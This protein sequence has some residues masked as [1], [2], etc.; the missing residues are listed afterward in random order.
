MKRK[1]FI[2]FIIILFFGSY[3]L[4]FFSYFFEDFSYLFED[5]NLNPF[6]Y[7][8]ITDIDYR[9]VVVD[10]PSS[11]GKVVITEK[12][13]FDIHAASKNNPFWELWRDLSESYVDGVKVDYK[14]NSVK[15]ILDD[16][17]EVIYEESPKLYW[18]DYDYINTQGRL[19]S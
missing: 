14:V 6:D 15:Q 18:D 3:L 5:I 16:G 13:T 11:N 10:E 9:A 7:A 8:R 1:L 4:E 19:W 12:L 2:W 17:T